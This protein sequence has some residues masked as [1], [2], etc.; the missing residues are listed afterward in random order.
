M[1]AACCINRKVVV[2]EEGTEGSTDVSEISNFEPNVVELPATSSDIEAGDTEPD[3]D[4][5]ITYESTKAIG[6]ADREVSLFSSL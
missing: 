6:V 4:T 5:N 3:E 1:A 2:N